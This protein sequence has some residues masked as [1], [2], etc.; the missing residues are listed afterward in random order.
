MKKIIALLSLLIVVIIACTTS[1]KSNN[2]LSKPGDVKA[3]EYSITIDRDTT[4]VTKNGALLKIPKGAL[5]T[6]NGNTVDLEIKEAYSLEQMIKYGLTTS[7]G[8][9]P[10]SS[11]GMIYIN[12]K[13]GQNVTIKQ[14][15]KVAIPANYL[16]PGMQLYKGETT[17][18]G[19]I[20]W[21]NP[22]LLP[23]NK[24]LASM[25]YGEQLFKTQCANCHSIG[26]AATGPE[27]A[28]FLKRFSGDTLLVRGYSLHIPGAYLY[29]DMKSDSVNSN[30]LRDK[31]SHI[32]PELW[33][34]QQLYFCNQKA[35][36]GSLG[37]AFP[38]LSENDLTSI[39]RYIQNESERR[40]L[41]VSSE[42]FLDDCIDSCFR[43]ISVT[44]Q[45]IKQQK[46]LDNRKEKL[47]KEKVP[48]V[49]E[50]KNPSPPSLNTP[51]AT[52][53]NYDEVVSPNKYGAVYYQFT[54]ETFGWYN[55]DILMK[56]F[57]GAKESELFVRIVGAY[58][59]KV[60]VYL[61]IPSAK[62]YVQG[63]PAE[64][65]KEEYA[66]VYKNGKI[67]LP[68]DVT[69]YIMAVTETES[70]IAYSVKEFN[71]GI[72]QELEL[73]LQLVTKEEF[74]TS[75]SRISGND[76]SISVKDAK[77]A[78]E[79]R[80]TVADLKTINEELKKAESLKPK[81][82]DCDCWK[83]RETTPSADEINEADILDWNK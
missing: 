52:P 27:L 11:G 47:L 22:A 78:S 14:A 76:I 32:S 16:E 64:R 65:N 23:E 69:A 20:N 57:N 39:Y 29:G 74:N 3:D 72:K 50:I 58:R 46:D 5:A 73:S 75:I 80:K 21:T 67:F 55:I 62:V 56:D 51:P 82:C 40:N 9:E 41:P 49:E 36:Y 35:R 42:A 44:D 70:S 34:N 7:S 28:H 63:G 77:N 4:L 19:N 31:L 79:I 30:P 66:F 53:L 45:L 24:Q 54:I 60:Q 43:Y 59:E 83:D 2:L 1:Q 18:D 26:K 33:Q 48:L 61:I 17:K 8:D 68:Q 81:N 25:N 13:A 37:T 6:D 71:T 12:A 38:G 15:I 10:L